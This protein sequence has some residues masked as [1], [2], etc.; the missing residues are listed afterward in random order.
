MAM[1]RSRTERKTPFDHNP[2]AVAWAMDAKGWTQKALAEA[3]GIS[4]S[5]MS[6]I[7]GGTRNAPPHLL[8]RLADALNCPVT[9]LERKRAAA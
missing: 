6:E 5:H 9:L 3:V 4:P 7:V 1:T 8:K 2:E